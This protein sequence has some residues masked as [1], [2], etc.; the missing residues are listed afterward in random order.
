MQRDSI[1]GID[2]S[3][4]KVCVSIIGRDARCK[5]VIMQDDRRRKVSRQL[6][7]HDQRLV[8]R[9]RPR[10]TKEVNPANVGLQFV[11][12]HMALKV[13]G[14]PTNLFQLQVLDGGAERQSGEGAV[15]VCVIQS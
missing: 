14:P 3:N 8:R 4:D 2:P 10:I 12:G 7:S 6:L 5:E 1:V 9:L 15:I 11:V 13:A